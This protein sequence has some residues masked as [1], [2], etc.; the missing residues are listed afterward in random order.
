MPAWKPTA[1]CIW[2]SFQSSGKEV[3]RIT[4]GRE[5]EAQALAEELV[6]RMKKEKEDFPGHLDCQVSSEA[7][8]GSG[9]VFQVNLDAPFG[10]LGCVIMG[11]GLGKRFGGN[12]L[13]AL[14]K[15]KPLIQYVLDATAG[16][17][18]RRVVVTRHPEV[19]ALCRA[20]GVRVVLHQEPYR[21]DTV[22]LGLEALAGEPALAGVMFCPGDQPLLE[23]ETV[24]ALALCGGSAPGKIWRA[25]WEG[26]PGAPVL[27]PAWAF[28]ELKQ[29][30]QGKGGG[31]VIRR[32]PDRVGL[33]PA[34]HPWE[35]A[36]V[37]RP[38]DL[39]AMEAFLSSSRKENT[40]PDA[41]ISF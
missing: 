6:R 9:P 39:E 14:L 38:E 17:F 34:R 31:A 33:V 27:F 41:L 16:I 5:G 23:R 3:L 2:N 35:L 19:A 7:V 12:K 15:G 18:A 25:S 20:E 21:S 26:K 10:E 29:L 24:A 36:D 28:E 30:P 13:L 40:G 8:K 4:G 22:R 37:D 1:D 32:Y 11:S